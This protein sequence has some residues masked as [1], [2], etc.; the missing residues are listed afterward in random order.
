MAEIHA[1]ACY[2]DRELGSTVIHRVGLTD[3]DPAGRWLL[4]C[5]PGRV[6]HTPDE[7]ARAVAGNRER[8]VAEL[9]LFCG[10]EVS[11]RDLSAVRVAGFQVH[12]LTMQEVAAYPRWWYDVARDLY[13][14][15]H[16]LG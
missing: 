5:R 14:Q 2:T 12:R 4:R 8:V 7:I 13:S 9:E 10:P 1:V 15:S 16:P 6:A 3:E 11:D